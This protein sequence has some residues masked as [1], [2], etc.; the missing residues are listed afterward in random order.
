MENESRGFHGN[1]IL[2][3][4]K[5]SDLTT[6]LHSVAPPELQED[7]DNAGLLIGDPNREGTGVLCTLDVTEEVVKEAI[8]KDCNLIVAHHP[9]IFKA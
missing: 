8:E 7:Y 2:H 5:I 6:Y 3:H 9:L 4:M 1:S